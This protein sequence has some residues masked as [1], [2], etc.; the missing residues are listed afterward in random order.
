MQSRLFKSY[1]FSEFL[2]SCKL[3]SVRCKSD[4]YQVWLGLESIAKVMMNRN[5]LKLYVHAYYLI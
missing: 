5:V 4:L 1:N 2:N 3:F